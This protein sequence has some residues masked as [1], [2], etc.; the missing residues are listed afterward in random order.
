MSPLLQ[1][2][3]ESKSARRQ[4]LRALSFPEKVRLVE[5]MQAAARQ[6]RV[7]SER[8]MQKGTTTGER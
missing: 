5:Q 4:R 2:T 6:I 1:K 8:A 7:V 3:L